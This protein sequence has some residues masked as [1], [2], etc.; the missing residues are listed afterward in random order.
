MGL[1]ETV[2]ILHNQNA[3]TQHVQ[4]LNCPCDIDRAETTVL[5]SVMLQGK[6]CLSRCDYFCIRNM[7]ATDTTEEQH[8]ILYS[9]GT[10][11]HATVTC[12]VFMFTQT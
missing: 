12:A 1:I 4:K 8:C 5:V 3:C 7:Q 9:Y 6:Y 2:V 11:F 10:N